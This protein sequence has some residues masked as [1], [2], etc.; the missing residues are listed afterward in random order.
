MLY[1]LTAGSCDGEDVRSCGVFRP[2]S[3]VTANLLSTDKSGIY[4]LLIYWM[5]WCEKLLK[6]LPCGSLLSDDCVCLV[7]LHTRFPN[8]ASLKT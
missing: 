8:P 1:R 6:C 5:L 2:S 7:N 4:I 3:T